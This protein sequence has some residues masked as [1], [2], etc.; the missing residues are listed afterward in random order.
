LFPNRRTNAKLS[1]AQKSVLKRK[2]GS[3][4]WEIKWVIKCKME[5]VEKNKEREN[6]PNETDDVRQRKTRDKAGK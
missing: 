6:K 2:R 5:D 1:T 3:E 4:G